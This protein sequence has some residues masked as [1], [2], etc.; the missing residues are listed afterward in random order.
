[1][2]MTKAKSK[3]IT[4]MALVPKQEYR[5]FCHACREFENKPWGR[6]K[7]K[8]VHYKPGV[9]MVKLTSTDFDQDW[10]GRK[11]KLRFRED[12]IQEITLLDQGYMT[13]T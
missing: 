4:V 12:G 8:K 5:Y 2:K 10:E 7:L 1:M 13:A 3:Y 11:V 6:I 9:F